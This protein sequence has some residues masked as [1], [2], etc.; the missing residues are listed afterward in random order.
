MA[1]D[2]TALLLRRLALLLRYPTAATGVVLDDLLHDAEEA[3]QAPLTAFRLAF[4]SL[5][6]AEREEI[7]TQAFD[8]GP[9]AVP[10]CSIHLYGEE[11]YKRGQLMAWLNGLY[12]QHG[13]HA[14]E[15]LPDHVR[16]VLEFAARLEPE[17][18]EA[19]MA[20]CVQGPVAAMREKLTVA[21]N[22]YA[23]V[24]QA[25]QVLIG[26][27]APAAPAP[28]MEAYHY[29]FNGTGRSQWE[30]EFRD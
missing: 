29:A 8:L 12:L 30:E 27:P 18:R 21:G 5:T 4:D 10:Y 19:L 14:E 9:L 13:M 6:Q 17:D 26:D 22:P 25:V 1:P 7:F 28:R 20:Y 11:S 24:L 2:A 15:E 3:I 23:H 16:L